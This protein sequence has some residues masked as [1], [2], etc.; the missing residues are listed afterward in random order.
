ML[1]PLN[2]DLLCIS[3]LLLERQK[4][5]FKNTFVLGTVAAVCHLTVEPAFKTGEWKREEKVEKII[6]QEILCK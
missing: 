5:S 1:F 2:T 3:H 4:E 6:F